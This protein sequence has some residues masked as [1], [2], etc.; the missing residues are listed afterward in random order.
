MDWTLSSTPATSISQYV[1][2]REC[3]LLFLYQFLIERRMVIKHL[4]GLEQVSLQ[5]MNAVCEQWH[6]E[7][8]V[9]PSAAERAKR[10]GGRTQREGS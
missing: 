4:E 6:R 10:S 9:M 1:P 2:K 5:T 7:V 3:F 8:N